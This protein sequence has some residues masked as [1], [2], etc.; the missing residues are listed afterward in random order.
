MERRFNLVVV[1][2]LLCCAACSILPSSTLAQ[3]GGSARSS[4]VNLDNWGIAYNGMLPQGQVTFTYSADGSFRSLSVRVS[5]IN[6]PDGTVVE[7]EAQELWPVEGSIAQNT[8]YYPMIIRQGT[9]TL[10][11]STAN[12]ANVNFLSPSMGQTI[13]F[14]ERKSSMVPMMGAQFGHLGG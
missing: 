5:R 4:T 12:D 11:L 7:V 1:E 9:G 3:R 6:V 2:F 14:E 8:V 10:A 13:L